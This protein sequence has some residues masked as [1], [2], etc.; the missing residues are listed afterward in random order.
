MNR[1]LGTAATR[2]RRWAHG[3]PQLPETEPLQLRP[4]R[5]PVFGCMLMSVPPRGRELAGLAARLASPDRAPLPLDL[6]LMPLKLLFALG[7]SAA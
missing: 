4:E 2:H 5:V 6:S 1:M 3:V 7:K